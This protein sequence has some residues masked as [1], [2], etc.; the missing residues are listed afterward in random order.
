[1]GSNRKLVSRDGHMGFHTCASLMDRILKLGGSGHIYIEF[2]LVHSHHSSFG[3]TNLGINVAVEI[4]SS[5]K[6]GGNTHLR[7][8]MFLS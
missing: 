3:T 5:D 8:T 4:N 2:Y 7:T 1:M 6:L